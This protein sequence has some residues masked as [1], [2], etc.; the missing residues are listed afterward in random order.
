VTQRSSLPFGRT[1]ISSEELRQRIDKEEASTQAE[2]GGVKNAEEKVED[3][4]SCIPDLL[5]WLEQRGREYP[6]RATTDSW[7]VY[8]AE[9]LLQR[10]RGDAVEKIYSDVIEQFPDP[11]A[12]YE[13]SDE[14]IRDT[15]HSLGFIN[16]RQRTLKEVGRIFTDQYDGEVPDSIDEL[17]KPWRVGDYSARATQLFARDRPLALVDANF[18]RVIGRVFGYEMPQQPHKSDEVY[19]FLQAMTPKDPA[20]ARSFNLAI[21]DL[22]SL[23][24]T[25]S[26]PDCESCPIN[27]ACQYYQSVGTEKN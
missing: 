10:T 6:W 15:V 5:K 3:F 27:A 24:C 26:D 13:A 21:L 14:E 18:A 20:V 19:G 23:V 16:H 2:K 7:K 25:P 22:G 11:E 9:I 17:K 4:V 8:L 1:D 12:L